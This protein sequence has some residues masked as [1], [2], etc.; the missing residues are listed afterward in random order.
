VAFNECSAVAAMVLQG[1]LPYAG[2]D[3]A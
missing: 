3:S 1:K 2:V